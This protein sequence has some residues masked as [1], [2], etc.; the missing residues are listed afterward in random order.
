MSTAPMAQATEARST[1]CSGDICINELMPNPPGTDTGNYPGCEWVEIYNSGT[2]DISLQGWTLVDAAQYSHAI[3]ASTWV[4]F[5]SL[6]TPYVLT[7][8][9]YAIIAENNQ[10]TLKLNNAGETLDLFDNT[11]IS[12]HTVSTGSASSDISKIPGNLPTD[13]YVDS[14]A[15]TPGAVNTGGTTGGPTFVE[16]EIRITEVMP[17]PYWTNDNGTWPGGEWVEIVNTG[18]NPIDLSGWAVEDAAGNML[19]MNATHLVGSS[20]MIQPDEY[21]IVSVNGTRAYGMLNNGQGTEKVKLKM[22]SG[23]I[24]HQ[25]EYTGPTR[26][27]HSYVN[28]SGMIPGWGRNAVPLDTA[29]WPTPGALNPP[30]NVLPDNQ[31]LVNEIMINA[32]MEGAVGGS[33]IELY[34]PVIVNDVDISTFASDY[35]IKTGTGM[36]SSFTQT[37]T[38][39]ENFI[40][41]E[42]LEILNSYDSVSLV[43]MNGY[44]R[45]TIHWDMPHEYNRS[46]IPTDSL[47]LDSVWSTSPYNTPGAF[48]PG[49]IGGNGGNQTTDVGLKISEFMPDPTG[50]DSQIGPDG[51]WVEITNTGNQS[52][53]LGGWELRTNSALSLSSETIYPGEYIVFYFGGEGVSLSN[54]QGT[55]QL[56]NPQ[57]ETIDTAIWTYTA[58][59]MSM[60]RDNSQMNWVHS[61]WPSPGLENP[62]IQQPY[63]GPLDVMI[64]ELSPQCS[65]QEEGL[66][67]EWIELHNF[68]EETVNLSRWSIRDS[69][70]DRVAIAP[71]RLWNQ[72]SDTMLLQS[73]QYVVVNIEINMLAN[74]GESVQLLDPD[75]YIKQGLAWSTSTDCISLEPS[76]DSNSN[77][78]ESLWPTPG[79]ENPAIEPYDGAMTIK[80]T[81]VMPVEISGNSNDWFEITN[82]G[83]TWVNLVGWGIVRHTSDSNS[84]STFLALNLEP[85]QSVVITEEPANL[86]DDGGPESM[87]AHDIFSNSPPWLINS[88]G[89]LQLIAPDGTV[90]DAF[91]YGSGYAEIEG[92]NGLALE[93]PPTSSEGLIYMRG[94]GCGDF[95]D[96][97]TS[98]DWQH[99]WLR[100]GASLHCDG[101]FMS[102]TGGLIP[103]NSPTGSL[104]Q[105]IEWIDG[106]TISLHLHVY[107]FSSPELFDAIS[108]AAQR[109]VEC[110]IL[111][112]G[113]ILGDSND[114]EN[115]RGWAAELNDI[116]CSVL[117]MIDSSESGTPSPYRYIHSKVAVK[118]GESVWIGSGNWKRSTFPLEGDAGNRDSGI[119]VNSQEVAD[120]VTARMQWDENTSR[121]HIVSFE[122][123]PISM[124]RPTGWVRP[125]ASTDIGENPEYADFEGTFGARLL[126]CPDDCIQS[127]VWMIDQSSETLDM[128]VQYFDLSWHWGY[129]DNPLIAAVERAAERG[130]QVRL[131]INGYYV[132]EDGGIQETVNHF[133]HRLNMT[134]GLDV[135]ARIMS[136]SENITKL[137]DKS[138]IVD[139]EWSLFSSIN[140]GSNSALRNREMGI[141]IQHEELAIHQTGVFED[142]WERLDATTDTD[143]DGMPDY[144]EI[145]YGLNR[146]MSAVLGTT[147]SE[148][149]LDPDGDGLA[150]LQEFQY[151]GDPQNPDTDG[152][153]IHDGDEVV[154]AWNIS[155]DAALAVQTTDADLDGMADNETIACTLTQLPVT[156][157]T[158]NTADNNEEKEEPGPFRENAMDS[159]SARILLAL[160]VIAAICLCG[161]LGMMFISTRNASAGRVLVDDVGDISGEIWSEQDGME[162]SGSVIL[163]GT[164]VGP[165]AVSEAREVSK[166][167]DDGVFGAPQL[168]GYDFPGWSPQKVQESLDAGWTLEQLR[169]KYDSGE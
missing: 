119:I 20:T 132:D 148:Q 84:V 115:Q 39:N 152:D 158:N 7:A 150:N 18:Q 162:Q 135:E 79:Q 97:D 131:L 98:Q 118:D 111:L 121:N 141:A 81:R 110:T 108:T 89:A 87:D 101:Q 138:L 127:L 73:G 31:L 21:R 66:T 151:G 120:L 59:G 147:N 12:V 67:N 112:E 49:Q 32:S 105:M 48:N 37:W 42:S 16:S 61:A 125:T 68:G 11:G 64:T 137:H 30:L 28:T 90:V 99:R 63:N 104:H 1:A 80:F 57:G 96:T 75:G 27:G 143:G 74:Q 166:G 142:D 114:H 43:D 164:S 58:Y 53:D 106:A 51:E 113:H 126:T 35:T 15:N 78:R 6:A 82:V 33:W 129:G 17:D 100:L 40:V 161:A 165:N 24:T 94:D 154:W 130:V 153:C 133:N 109:G 22:P 163:D 25:I 134:D 76:S 69:S 13:D 168:D 52:I 144:W 2:T 167:R 62:A 8:G 157:T 92:W 91:V 159:T 88:G 38:N 149:N 29:A 156:P 72:T 47:S 139:G 44:I 56:N 146:A 10:G 50:S 86:L 107:Q 169:E 3:D 117:W 83:Q 41:F 140:W 103:V 60:I 36:Q 122:N 102:S 4:D 14:N 116:G 93:G 26:P 54:G 136:A 55:L 70:E 19:L 123:A 65:E 5:G 23:E 124:G 45:Q 71:G 128:G 77:S 46:I 155:I 34:Y 85:G 160:V 145:M 95:P 9:S